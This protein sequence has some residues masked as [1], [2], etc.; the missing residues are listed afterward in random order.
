[1]NDRGEIVITG[2]HIGKRSVIE[3]G[4]SDASTEKWVSC[5]AIW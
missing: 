2:K 5:L 3:V 1:M 4:Q